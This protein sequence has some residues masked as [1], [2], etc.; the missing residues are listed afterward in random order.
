MAYLNDIVFNNSLSERVKFDEIVQTKFIFGFSYFNDLFLYQ[1][2]STDG[3]LLK[4]SIEIG[5]R[6]VKYIPMNEYLVKQGTL[7]GL[8]RQEKKAYEYFKASCHYHAG[9]ECDNT[10]TY[11]KE[12]ALQYPNNFNSIY[13]KIDTNF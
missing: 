4:D 5:E 9:K 12:L 2:L 1:S 11:L 10:K 13:K 6:L 7:L 8:D 3:F